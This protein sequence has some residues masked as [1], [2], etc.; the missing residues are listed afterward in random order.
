MIAKINRRVKQLD[1]HLDIKIVYQGEEVK[2]IFERF[3]AFSFECA[4]L[5][6]FSSEK[7]KWFKHVR[8]REKEK[9]GNG[10]SP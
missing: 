7:S 4:D 5:I 2:T 6:L 9:A 10:I 1:K 3:A 8:T